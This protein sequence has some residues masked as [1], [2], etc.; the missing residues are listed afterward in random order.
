[1]YIDKNGYI[2]SDFIIKMIKDIKRMQAIKDKNFPN[3]AKPRRISRNFKTKT[4]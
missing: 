2:Y 1:M 3:R 4:A